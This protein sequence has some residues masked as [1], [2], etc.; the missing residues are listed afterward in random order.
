MSVKKKNIHKMTIRYDSF[1]S[2]AMSL[3]ELYEIKYVYDLIPSENM[4]LDIR[5]LKTTAWKSFLKRQSRLSR[6]HFFC[7]WVSTA[8]ENVQRNEK[9]TKN[10]YG[11]FFTIFNVI[12]CASFFFSLFHFFFLTIQWTLKHQIKFQNH[13]SSSSSS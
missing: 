11:F 3:Q 12:A 1:K 2:I 7:E 6:Q 5:F 4:L 8:C 13:S 9:Y 10:I